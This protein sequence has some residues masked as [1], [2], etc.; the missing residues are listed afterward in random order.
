MRLSF[1]VEYCGF[2]SGSSGVR[3]ETPPCERSLFSFVYFSFSYFR[4]ALY[5]LDSIA[6]IPS[7]DVG[8]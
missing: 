1:R 3:L 6:F 2:G 5:Y 7:L 4:I 8:T